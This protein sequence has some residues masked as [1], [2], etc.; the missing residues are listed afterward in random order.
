MIGRAGRGAIYSL[1]GLGLHAS[2][3]ASAPPS[4][5]PMSA[6]PGRARYS[7]RRGQGDW[8]AIPLASTHEL[9]WC[10][11]ES[12]QEAEGITYDLHVPEHVSSSLRNV[13][14]PEAFAAG[15]RKDPDA[16]YREALRGDPALRSGFVPPVRSTVARPRLSEADKA[17]ILGRSDLKLAELKKS[18]R[19]LLKELVGGNPHGSQVSSL[20]HNTTGIWVN[21]APQVRTGQT[22]RHHPRTS[23]EVGSGA[24]GR[25][26]ERTAT[27]DRALKRWLN[28][29]VVASSLASRGAGGGGSAMGSTALGT[30][31]TASASASVWEAFENDDASTVAGTM[32]GA[33]MAA[34]PGG[35]SIHQAQWERGGADAIDDEDAYAM[36]SLASLASLESYTP[37]DSLDEFRCVAVDVVRARRTTVTDCGALLVLAGRS[38][39]VLVVILNYRRVLRYTQL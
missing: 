39:R 33:Q 32:S 14:A 25:V 5:A 18:G 17:R 34:S 8:K 6:D 13:W 28:S 16:I 20:D 36:A 11:P 10:T 2:P 12:V 1:A 4:D 30:T 15:G 9:T 22:P 24:I 21:P 38:Y 29:G 27:T 3:L 19:M 26:V 7:R 35:G 31:V 37:Q 23:D